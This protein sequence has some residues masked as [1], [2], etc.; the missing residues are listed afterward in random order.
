MFKVYRFLYG[1]FGFSRSQSNGF[2]I[3][4]PLI[5]CVF[6]SEPVYRLF[7]SSRTIDYSADV[8]RLD[9]LVRLFTPKTIDTAK[10]S[11][12]VATPFD[13]NTA[14]ASQLTDAG[15]HQRLATRIVNY[16]NRGGRF[17]EPA[18]LLRIY[19]MDSATFSRIQPYIRIRR[20]EA[21]QGEG[22]G[23][24][25]EE[26]KATPIALVDLNLADSTQLKSVY[27]IG[28]RLANRITRYRDKLGGFVSMDQ[29]YEVYRLDSVIVSALRKRFTITDG[30]VPRKLDLN[31][32]GRQELA[33]HPYLSPRAADAIV[34]YRL[35]HGKFLS[36]EEIRQIPALDTT[37]LRRS[38]PYLQVSTD[39]GD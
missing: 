19:G 35:K 30:F 21:S 3:L 16:R 23:K 20:Y 12:P 38:A 33:A 32:V 7:L 15:I 4:L 2:L 17:K 39:Q 37:M 5:L 25:H 24:V 34:A 22:S 1:V 13:P 36:I 27:G 29:L 28:S 26:R 9:S 6:F 10:T 8:A 11:L 31:A 18:D 14:S